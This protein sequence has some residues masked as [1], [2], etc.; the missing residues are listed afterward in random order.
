[1]NRHVWCPQQGM[2]WAVVCRAPSKVVP[3]RAAC[4]WLVAILFRM[5]RLAETSPSLTRS[6]R[7]MSSALSPP[8]SRPCQFFLE[9][10]QSPVVSQVSQVCS[11]RASPIPC[12]CLLP[13]LPTLLP[14]GCHFPARRGPLCPTPP[15]RGLWCLQTR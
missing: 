10:L 3:P 13:V 1:M 12:S 9:F 4:S 11:P 14:A 6:H 2:F 7:G 5:P 8:P 15:L